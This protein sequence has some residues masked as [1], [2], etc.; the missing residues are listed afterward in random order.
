MALLIIDQLL[1]DG[2]VRNVLIS[3]HGQTVLRSQMAE[4]ASKLQAEGLI[5]FTF[6]MLTEGKH[7]EGDLPQV[8]IALPQ[9]VSRRD[10]I[11]GFDLVVVDEAHEFFFAADGMLQNIIK[12]CSARYTI[13]LTGTPSKFIADGKFPIVAAVSVL[14]LLEH[15]V[16][17]S[18]AIRLATSSYDFT[19]DDYTA[20]DNLSEK[21][22]GTP[23][24]T[25]AT[26]DD[27]LS[28]IHRELGFRLRTSPAANKVLNVFNLQKLKEFLPSF[29]KTMFACHS[30]R[31]ARQVRDY[32]EAK[33]IS[34]VL[35]T[36][37]DGDDAGKLKKFTEDPKQLVL[38][39]V[40]RGILGFSCGELVN[41]VD[42]TC[43]QNVDRLA[44]LFGRILRLHPD[45]KEKLFLKVVPHKLAEYN[46]HLLS[47]VLSLCARENYITYDGDVNTK[48]FRERKFKEN[49]DKKESKST[50]TRKQKESLP[51]V[52]DWDL[53]EL[54]TK[55]YTKSDEPLSDY[56]Q[57]TLREVKLQLGML[58]RRTP[59]EW[60]PLAKKLAA[61]NGGKLQGAR[62][63]QKNYP[64]LSVAMYKRPD[65]FV[66]IPREDKMGGK[67]PEEWVSDADRLVL[68]NG[69][70]LHRVS[71]LEDNGYSGLVRAMTNRPELF[72][73]IK[74]ESKK[75]PDP[76]R[77]VPAAE[78]LAAEHEGELPSLKWMR[79]NGRIGLANAIENRGH[80]FAHIPRKGKSTPLEEQ[81]PVADKLVLE[82]DGVLPHAGWLQKNGHKKLYRAMQLRPELFT[83]IT[84]TNKRL[85]PEE[86]VPVADKLLEQHEGVFPTTNWLVANGHASLYNAMRNRP[87]LFTHIPRSK[88]GN[89]PEEWVPEADRLALENGGLLPCTSWLEDNE[90]SGLCAAMTKRPELFSHLKQENKRKDDR[91]LEEWVLFAKE[92]AAE[93]GGILQGAG[94]ISKNRQRLYQAI[95]R[96]PERFADIPQEGKKSKSPEEWFLFAKEFAAGNGGVLPCYSWL[97]KHHPG[98]ASAIHKHPDLFSDIPQENKRKDERSAEEW[99]L[100]AKELAAENKGALQCVGWVQKSHPGLAHAMRRHPDLFI[101]IPQEAKRKSAVGPLGGPSL[102]ADSGRDFPAAA[103]K[104]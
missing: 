30:I 14:D 80:M 66:D 55:V 77:W 95:R 49:G 3:T 20:D 23:E 64:G 72:S 91:S 44:Q 81:V 93:N 1:K 62:W 56:A 67:R 94:W 61:E 4:E 103:T 32:F 46:Y 6:D 92:L 100:F 7:F 97:R 38:I 16:V 75:N 31:Q 10:R 8:V 40:R 19:Q 79:D 51:P 37:D 41:L 82:H 29:G 59:E 90:Y 25:R 21:A 85:S 48:P 15:N 12:D 78:E 71:W 24:Q 69:G 104:L 76:K 33:G 17:T 34:A 50:G 60:V 11:P 87:E 35:S 102:A 22:H 89:S 28:V 45:G 9:T 57:T 52:W 98:L 2:T 42:M 27:V 43:T 68:E 39:V 36:S 47:F 70:L 83:H 5:S 54:L 88:K 53:V 84:Q 65:L 58:E 63:V 18:P 74:Q 86:L 73:H 99:V 13:F 96:C 101:G 26:M